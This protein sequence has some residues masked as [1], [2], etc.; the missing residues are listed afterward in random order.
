MTLTAIT[1]TGEI[2]N[3]SV[4]IA[5]GQDENQV[6][7]DLRILVAEGLYCPHCYR[8]FGELMSVTFVNTTTKVKH[9]RHVK[10]DSSRPCQHVSRE[11]EQHMTTKKWIGQYYKRQPNVMD[12]IVDKVRIK[13]EQG[14]ERQP[15]VLV[16]Y[17]TGAREGHEV[18]ISPIPVLQIQSRTEDMKSGGAF[19]VWYLSKAACTKEVRYWLWNNKIRAFLLDFDYSEVPAIIPIDSP[20]LN[21]DQESRQGSLID[22]CRPVQRIEKRERIRSHRTRQE[23][24]IASSD[25]QV[26]DRVRR[27]SGL[28]W[29]GGIVK[30]M[31][32]SKGNV[33]IYKVWW[34]QRA[35]PQ[36][37]EGTTTL[38][39]EQ[40]AMQKEPVIAHRREQLEAA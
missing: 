37:S 7:A 39:M 27:T 5:Q 17:K 33:L 15:D 3:P 18:Q 29:E 16:I 1:K 20:P 10:G 14:R 35:E 24:A 12:A 6:V 25:I 2:Y 23:E 8:R 4:E 9:F 21:D 40:K 11:S 30:Q 32:L 22:D 19:P 36:P 13:S 34:P 38:T 31:Y 26:G 28:M